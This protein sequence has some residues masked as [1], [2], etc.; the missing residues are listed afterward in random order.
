M[1][2][3]GSQCT[4]TFFCGAVNRIRIRACIRPFSHQTISCLRLCAHFRQIGP[5]QPHNLDLPVRTQSD[6]MLLAEDCIS[7]TS[8]YVFQKAITQLLSVIE[9]AEL[10]QP[11]SEHIPDCPGLSICRNDFQHPFTNKTSAL[12]SAIEVLVPSF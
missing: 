11:V 12:S 5:G 8:S 9:G 10:S 7:T 2:G 3:A 6:P 1:K 4:R